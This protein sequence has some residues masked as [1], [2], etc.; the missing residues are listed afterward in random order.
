M[1]YQFPTGSS[2]KRQWA[3]EQMG[4]VDFA[5]HPLAVS[6]SRSPDALNMICD[7]NGQPVCRYGYELVKE[8]AGRI[9]GIYGVD[10]PGGSYTLVHHGTKISLWENDGTITEL[11][12]GCSDDK[13]VAAVVENKWYFFDGVKALVYGE[14][15][16][17]D[18]AGDDT[19]ETEF[20]L[21][22]LEEAAYIP[23]TTIGRTVGK[24][25]GNG[26]EA[27]NM[28]TRRRKNTFLCPEGSIENVLYLDTAPILEDGVKVRQLMDDGNWVLIDAENYTVNANDGYVYLKETTA[29]PVTGMDNYEVEFAVKYLG[30]KKG[31]KVFIRGGTAND[32]PA[33]E[34]IRQG[35]YDTTSYPFRLK[36]LD[37]SAAPSIRIQILKAKEVNGTEL[38]FSLA[39]VP[40]NTW[41]D[42]RVYIP[43]FTPSGSGHGEG[44]LDFYYRWRQDGG[45]LVVDFCDPIQAYTEGYVYDAW[46]KIEFT[47]QTP[48]EEYLDV[49]N[50]CT[51][52]QKY[53]YGGNAD[54]LFISGNEYKKNFDW[55]SAYHD[56][57]YWPDLNYTKLGDEDTAIMGYSWLADGS[58][59]VHK[60]WN[61]QDSSIYIRT[62]A[63]LNDEVVFPI[64]QGAVGVG[65]ISKRGFGYL[66]NEPL[67]FSATGVF[68]TSPL[69]NV[70]VDERYA[71]YRSGF[72][73]PKLLA[74]G[75][76]DQAEAV[77]FRGKYYLALNGHVYVADGNRKSYVEKGQDYSFEW[78]Y[79]ENVPV[80]VWW[81]REDELYFGT[82][83]GKVCKFNQG[84]FDLE[85]PIVSY[86]KTPILDFGT[87]LYY[88]K[89]KNVAAVSP[90]YLHS[91]V[92]IRYF[93][94]RTER[95]AKAKDLQTD[96]F[97]V[98]P[99]NTP[100]NYKAKKALQFQLELSGNA[101]EPFGIYG[102]HILYS[103]GG[104]YKG[105]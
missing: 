78:F 11:Y 71:A 51:I 2:G 61:G 42:S 79:W 23:T 90:P 13:S 12:D 39:D 57:T 24:R 77:V 96:E 3:V 15:P 14:Y 66:N 93:D 67:A 6:E 27:V 86:W 43:N 83:D 88:K 84:Y 9:N 29:T 10:D 104:K 73:N 68:A 82:E 70:A 32:F 46:R 103:I 47:Y 81:V 85:E 45:D 97:R 56:P 74:E 21:K 4:G 48:D 20:L 44:W 50:H 94:Q 59:A 31:S 8:F 28:A 49:V 17:L 41:E 91:K 37:Q 18:E 7:A 92:N 63:M 33:G 25:D 76:L 95:Q 80:R 26:L 53:G 98:F 87:E 89:I 58:L 72:I 102:I 54:R 40:E 99:L 30:A 34:E 65:V 52:V 62:S 75:G 60:E 55:Y 38:S 1:A 5:H 22:T 69:E 64:Q 19:G 35:N 16:I 100:S 105:V 101:G 36:Y